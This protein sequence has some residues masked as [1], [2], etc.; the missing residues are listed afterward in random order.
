MV[1][2]QLNGFGVSCCWFWCQS[3]GMLADVAHMSRIYSLSS[4]LVAVGDILLNL[5]RSSLALVVPFAVG[6]LLLVKIMA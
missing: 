5:K 4:S 3:V 6:S 1:G 2:M